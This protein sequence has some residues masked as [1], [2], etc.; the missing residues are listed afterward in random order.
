MNIGEKMFKRRFCF[1]S[2]TNYISSQDD[3]GKV[4][5]PEDKEGGIPRPEFEEDGISI[6]EDKED[7]VSVTEVEAQSV[8]DS[9]VKKDE[10]DAANSALTRDKLNVDSPREDL[11]IILDSFGC[12]E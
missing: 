6:P 9:E 3:E 7:E 2:I 8:I 12:N 1:C 4:S 11:D 5:G 10:T